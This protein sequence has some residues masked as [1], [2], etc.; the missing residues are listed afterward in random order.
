M[1]KLVRID[2]WLWA[3][4]FYK[5][6]SMATNAVEGGKVHVN[7]KRIKPS[8]R[9]KV[10]DVVVMTK[11]QYKI[12]VIVLKLHGQRR[13]AKEAQELYRESDESV[14]QRE[15][16]ATKRKIMNQGI[17]RMKKKPGKHERRK[18]REMIGKTK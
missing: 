15:L 10:D 17:P 11:P 3:A 16:T 5:T 1:E 9:V 4:R 18:I 13:S 2:K 7:T 8:Y 14:A 6:R 12:E